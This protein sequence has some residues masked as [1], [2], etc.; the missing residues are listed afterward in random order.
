VTDGNNP[1]V[2]AAL[3]T[4]SFTALLAFPDVYRYT[5]VDRDVVGA[6]LFM[7]DTVSE[8]CESEIPRPSHPFSFSCII[9]IATVY[10]LL[11]QWGRRDGKRSSLIVLHY[12]SK[13]LKT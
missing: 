1:A 13:W 4:S 2:F 8:L 5:P 7:T 11:N 6:L 3:N 9:Y 12:E 10:R